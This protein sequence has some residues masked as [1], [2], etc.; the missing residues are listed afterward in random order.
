VTRKLSR[1]C[2]GLM[3][4][5]AVL[6]VVGSADAASVAPQADPVHGQQVFARCTAC[7]TLGASGGKM[8]PSLNG[9]VGRKAASLP[10]YP[11][12]P[13][14]KNSGF[15]WNEATLARFLEAPMKVV[16]GTKMFF[17]GL[18]NA[19]DRSDVIA[20]LKQYKTDGTKK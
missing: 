9:V 18:P 13:A 11:Y 8:G 1:A 19:Q 10:G 4:L 14:M 2:S 7:H 3:T 15:T 6:L 17:P 16:P 5:A 12:S 20:L